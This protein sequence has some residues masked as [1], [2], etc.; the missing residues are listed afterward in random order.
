MVQA[1]WTHWLRASAPI[2]PHPVII[3][4]TG[5]IYFTAIYRVLLSHNISARY[6]NPEA[7]PIA[8][9]LEE[10]ATNAPSLVLL[11]AWLDGELIAQMVQELHGTCQLIIVT[12]DERDDVLSSFRAL[13]IENATWLTLSNAH[14]LEQ[15]LTHILR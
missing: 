1:T 9:V 11:G 3:L 13:S 14:A 5:T 15:F 7:E 2:G 6:I 12:W 4:D 10:V 8:A